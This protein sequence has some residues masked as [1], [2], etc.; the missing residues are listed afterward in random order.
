L[1][2][3]DDYNYECFNNNRENVFCFIGTAHT[4]RFTIVK[5]L[6]SGCENSFTFF[7]CPNLLVYFFKRLFKGELTA[8]QLSDVSFVPLDRHNVIAKIL[9]SSII[10]DIPHSSQVGLTMRSVEMLG[11]KRKFITTNS[12]IVEYD[13]FN[14]Q[15]ILVLTDDTTPHDI[16][17]FI[18]MPYFRLSDEIYQ[19]YTISSWVEYL[20]FTE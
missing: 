8:L 2:Y 18:S 17:N 7:Y 11:V 13:F 12:R 15:N 19:K 5:K 3:C 20:F 1:F 4:Q 10:I 9:D 14:S 16:E 6:L